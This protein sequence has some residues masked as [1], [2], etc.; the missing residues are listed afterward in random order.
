MGQKVVPPPPDRPSVVVMPFEN[1]SGAGDELLADGFVE[2][3]TA[4]LSRVRDFFVI[5]RQSAFAG[6]E[7][8]ADVRQLGQELGVRY[9]IQG[10]LRRSGSNVRITVRLVEAESRT[11]LWTERY[12]GNTTDVFSLQDRIAEQVAGAMHPALVQAEIEAAKRKPPGSLKAYELVLQAQAKMWKRVESENRDAIRL[13]NQAIATDPHY[14]RAYALQAWCHS[15]N[16]VYLWTVEADR[17]RQVIRKAIDAAAPLIGDDPLAMTALGAA[18]GQS[19]EERDR[20][21]TYIEAALA[22]DPNS[23][24]AW[25]RRG[26]IILQDEEFEAAKKCFE[27]ALR[28]SPLDPLAFNF[29]FGIATCLGHM[30]EYEQAS[31]LLR[32]LL[33]LYPDVTWG[34]R[35]LAAFAALAGDMETA[36]ASV[37]ALLEAQPSASI[38]L[39]KHNHPSRNTPGIFNRLLKGWRLAGLPEE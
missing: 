9:V 10:A 13:L 28:L 7:R 34:H 14:G 30:E 12:E 3:I 21:R 19:L 26:W 24:W 18:L 23:A 22:L 39:M 32:E 4:T 35:M 29:R 36:R 25:A 1:L 27:K 31:R 37:K 20:A 2:E 5:A 33:N 16:V 17:E 11:L 6:K 8:F 38:V 15:Q